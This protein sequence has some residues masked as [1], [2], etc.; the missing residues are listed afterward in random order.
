MVCVSGFLLDGDTA[1]HA[2]AWF[3]T[4]VVVFSFLSIK[5]VMNSGKQWRVQH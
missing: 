3:R 5:S 2:R 1:V 4:S